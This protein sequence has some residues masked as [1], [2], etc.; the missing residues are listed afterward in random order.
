[1]SNKDVALEQEAIAEFN[2]LLP[3]LAGSSK[4]TVGERSKYFAFF[5]HGWYGRA[6]EGVWQDDET[7]PT[8]E[9]KTCPLESVSSAIAFSPRD[10]SLEKHDAW[11]YGVMLGWEDALP[12]IQKQFRWSDSTVSRMVMLNKKVEAIVGK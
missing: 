4:W 2:K 12:I 7:T 6:N 9:D 5:C 3:F 1:M 10:W 8:S 11:V